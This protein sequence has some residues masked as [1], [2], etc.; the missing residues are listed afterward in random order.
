MAGHSVEER[1][2]HLRCPQA[3]IL[4]SLVDEQFVEGQLVSRDVSKP[5]GLLLNEAGQV[6]RFA[7]VGHQADAEGGLG[8]DGP[9][10]QQKLF[11]VL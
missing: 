5:S 6:F 10:S 9:P 8:V 11:G 4:E 3:H 7:N 1:A 2:Q